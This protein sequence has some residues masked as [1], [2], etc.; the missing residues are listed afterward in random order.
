[1]AIDSTE[2]ALD[3]NPNLPYAWGHQA[4]AYLQM[5]NFER[6]EIGFKRMLEIRPDNDWALFNLTSALYYQR[7]HQEASQILERLRRTNPTYP[8]IE[9]LATMLAKK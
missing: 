1:M 3:L 4:V 9:L 2:R 6:G 8:R 7:K 5:G